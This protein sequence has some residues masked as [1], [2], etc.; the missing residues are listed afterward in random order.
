MKKLMLSMAALLALACAAP[1]LAMDTRS[2]VQVLAA[3][4]YNGFLKPR[5]AGEGFRHRSVYGEVV[6]I[7]EDGREIVIREDYS[8]LDTPVK[9]KSEDVGRVNVGDEVKVL[10]QYNNT[11]VAYSLIIVDREDDEDD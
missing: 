5:P 7:N 6:E 9:L 4:T 10:L 11:N 1:G 3:E 2:G 8:H